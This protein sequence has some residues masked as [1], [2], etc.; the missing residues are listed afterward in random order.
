MI[1]FAFGFLMEVI[2]Y[3]IGRATVAVLSLGRIRAERFRDLFPGNQVCSAQGTHII[4][5]IMVCQ[6]IGA[7]VLVAFIRLCFIVLK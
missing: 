3:G 5:P 2:L 1:E 7:G 4:V 6:L